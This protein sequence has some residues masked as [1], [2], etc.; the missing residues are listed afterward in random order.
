MD[1]I[2]VTLASILFC[3]SC[4]LIYD[5]IVNGFDFL[6]LAVCI[7]G[8]IAVHFLIPKKEVEESVWYEFLAGVIDIP[9]RFIALILRGVGSL[10]H[11]AAYF[12]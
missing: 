3:I 5:L 9:F 1:V 11:G 10:F 7:V 12:D 2:R 6:V 8:Y 4:Y